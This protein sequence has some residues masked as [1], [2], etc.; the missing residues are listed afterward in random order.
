MADNSF[1]RIAAAQGLLR[2]PSAG[3]PP[4][5]QAEQ[6]P[7]TASAPQSSHALEPSESFAYK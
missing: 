6:A 3:A 4:A 5:R 7:A 1:R 2:E